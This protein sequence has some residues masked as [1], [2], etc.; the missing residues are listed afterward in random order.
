M[1]LQ[2]TMHHPFTNHQPILP[3]EDTWDF[4]WLYSAPQLHMAPG[5]DSWSH[6][7]RKFHI[8]QT[9]TGT[10]MYINTHTHTNYLPLNYRRCETPFR[11]SA[12]E[13]ETMAFPWFSIVCWIGI[14][15]APGS[16]K[17]RCLQHLW[18]RYQRHGQRHCPRRGRLRRRRCASWM[19]TYV[20]PPA[21]RHANNGEL[22][23]KVQ[24]TGSR[25]PISQ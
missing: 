17:P 22:P 16:S 13:Q 21:R 15:W 6:C 10:Y 20:D 25:F 1:I 4:I 24:G 9:V 11:K 2:K 3:G 12:S 5:K 14:H 19:R 23:R 8:K 18:S 7:P